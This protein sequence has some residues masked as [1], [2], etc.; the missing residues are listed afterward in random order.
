MSNCCGNQ[1]LARVPKGSQVTIQTM[2]NY[3]AVLVSSVSGDDSVGNLFRTWLGINQEERV[4]IQKE[5]HIHSR[6][7]S[8]SCGKQRSARV[9]QL[10]QVTIKPTANWWML[11]GKAR[12]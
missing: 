8:N 4:G 1:R 7:M 10:S 6:E 2:A 9:P 5:V 12:H 11:G 3:K